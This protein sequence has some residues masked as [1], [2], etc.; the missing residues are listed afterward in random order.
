QLA[1]T[2]KLY[3]AYRAGR[4]AVMMGQL[5]ALRAGTALAGGWVGA[6]TLGLTLTVLGGLI[7]RS[8]TQN[9][10][11][12]QWVARTRF[13]VNRAAW[14]GNYVSEMTELYKVV[15][16][17]TLELE[18]YPELNPRT[19]DHIQVTWLILRLPAQT[20]LED[21]MIHF[22]GAEVWDNHGWLGLRDST[23]LVEW[24]GEDFDADIGSRRPQELG[25]ARYRRVY[26]EDKLLGQLKKFRG[27][28][29]YTPLEGVHLPPLVLE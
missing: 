3:R 11:L 9:T 24:T 25:V 15:F 1:L 6:V 26:H 22:T 12:E 4:L 18:R 23:R 16:P 20:R 29:V 8:Y 19:S 5:A 28:L 21:W 27:K 14:A 13:G 17:I 2:I 10:P 7:A